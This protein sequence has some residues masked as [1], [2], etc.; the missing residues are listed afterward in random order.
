LITYVDT[1]T[2]IKLVV[3]EPGSE[4]AEAIWRA[5]EDLASVNLIVV[6][7]RATLAAA[8]RDHRLT[9]RQYRAARAD[10]DALLGDLHLV[11]PA[12][13][14]IEIAATLAESEGLRGY[15]AVHLAA[16]L[17][18]DATVLTSADQAL[19]RA[20]ERRGLHVANP[21]AVR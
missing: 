6:E 8:H 17:T 1:S 11:E 14:L 3:D 12:G 20:A 10:L 4:G 21:L 18:V 9:S 7:A 13:D 16:A 5:A 19:C 2:L 15:D